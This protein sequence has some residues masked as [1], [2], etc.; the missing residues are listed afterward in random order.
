VDRSLLVSRD[1]IAASLDKPLTL[2]DF[3]YEAYLSPFHFHRRFVHQFGVTPNEFRTQLRLEE[4][5]RLLAEDRLSVGDICMTV[6][7]S[8]QGSFSSL[9]AQRFGM[10]PQEF[11]RSVRAHFQLTGY[12]GHLFVPACFFGPGMRAS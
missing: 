11:R 10:S 8:S 4:A 2:A 9:F 12:R 7:Y 6:G 5:R 3:A 1:F